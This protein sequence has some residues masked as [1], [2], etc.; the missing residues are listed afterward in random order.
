MPSAPR[1]SGTRTGGAAVRP[2]PA[3]PRN[4]PPRTS[5][6]VA[7]YSEGHAAAGRLHDAGLDHPQVTRFAAWCFLE[8]GD[9]REVRPSVAASVADKVA[10]VEDAQRRGTVTDRMARESCSPSSW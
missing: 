10:A 6:L 1:G 9:G 8:R 2:R 5:A 7:A 4:R 3:G